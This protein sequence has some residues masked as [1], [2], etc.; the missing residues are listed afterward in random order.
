[1]STH[2]LCFEQNYEEMKNIRIFYLKIFIFFFGGKIVNVF[3]KVCFHTG[4][5][6]SALSS[7]VDPLI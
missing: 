5:L 2:N 3:E 1:M 6:K 4:E 7:A